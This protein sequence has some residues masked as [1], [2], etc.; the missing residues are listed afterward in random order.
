MK[1][2]EFT[3][4][5]AATRALWELLIGLLIPVGMT[6]FNMSM[7]GVALPTVRDAFG[8]EA[9]LAAWM[10][11]AYSLPFVIFMPLYG[12]LGDSLGKARLFQ[13][14]IVLFFIG[15]LVC[16]LA[17]NLPQLLI[18]RILQGTG[19]AGFYPLCIAIIAERFPPAQQGRAMGTWSSVAPGAAML[20]PLLGGFAVD[21]LGWNYVFLPSLL[22]GVI[23]LWVVYRQVPAQRPVSGE[24]LQA[25]D[26]PGAA[27]LGGALV[28]AMFYLSSRMVSGVEPLRDWRLLA[29]AVG[30]GFLFW[31]RQ[32]RVARHGGRAAGASTPLVNF[33]LY[34]RKNFGVA[35]MAAGCRM[36]IMHTV[37]FLHVLYLTD[38]YGLDATELGLFSTVFAGAI[39]ATTRLGGQLSD[40]IHCRWIVGGSFVIQCSALAGLALLSPPLLG[41]AALILA[42]GLGGGLALAAL[43]RAAME[44]IPAAESGAAAGLYSTARFGG[45]VVGATVAGAAL[46]QAQIFAPGPTEAFQWVF[47]AVAAISLASLFVAWK[48]QR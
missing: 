31:R 35:S 25:F 18:G 38:V 44:E 7:F 12:K 21:H 33:A 23:A 8:A 48:L 43:H 34:R 30:L 37:N 10:L 20:G 27:F 47:G 28:F 24:G 2:S 29:I 46:Q 36:T 32:V 40:R 1:S 4:T 13:S 3:P 11:T 9:D 22:I 6:T 39:L 19:T 17:R 16:L 42:Q 15:T 26:W 5:T 45:G 41:A 14:G